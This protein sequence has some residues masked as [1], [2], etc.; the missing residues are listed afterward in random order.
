LLCPLSARAEPSQGGSL[1][2]DPGT[3]TLREPVRLEYP[4]EAGQ[5]HGDVR[6]RLRVSAQGDVLAVLAVEGPAVFAAAAERAAARL[7]FAPALREGRPVEA[8]VSVSF[9]FA[10]PEPLPIEEIVVT[11]EA[12]RHP[13]T[14][15]VAVL[16]KAA[17]DRA[18][19]LGLA[20]A[21]AT[22]PGVWVAPGA[23]DVAKPIVRGQTE[24]R[25]LVLVDGVRHESQKWGADHAPEIDPLLAGEVT[26][27]RGAAGVRYGP[28]A[29]GGVIL[30]DALPLRHEPGV[31]G[32]VLSFG[33]LNGPH[34]GAAA[35][36][37][38]A[39]SSDWSWRV[40][41][42]VQ[43]GGPVMTPTYR[44]GNTASHQR[45]VGA[46]LEHH[47][48]AGWARLS[49]T[50][51]HQTAGIYYG[52]STATPV[53]FQALVEADRPVGAD[54]WTGDWRI[55]RPSQSVSHDRVLAQSRLGL[56]QDASLETSYAF[57]LNH[58]REF[59]HARQGVE[60]PQFN[61]L[62]R[63]HALDLALTLPHAHLGP[64][65]LDSRLGAQGSFQE[66]VYDGL[67]LIPN[68]RSFGGGAYLL[69]ELRT[70]R[71]GLT[72]GARY[73]ALSRRAFFGASDFERHRDRGTLD[74]R[75]C[76]GA[77]SA[78]SCR[79]LYDALT[80]TLGG[81]LRAPDQGWE[82][83]LDLSSATRFPQVD[84]LYL[85][86]T[87]PSTPVF[88]LGDPGLAPETTWGASPTARLSQPWLAAELSAWAQR[89][90]RYIQFA[91]DLNP[92]GQP[93]F[94]VTISGAYPRFAFSPVTAALV[95]ADATLQIGPTSPV[96]VDLIGALVRG[97]AQET[98][99]ALLGLPGD[100]ARVSLVG[101]PPGP[102]ATRL[103]VHA[104]AIGRQSRVNPQ[105]DL[106]PPP[107]GAVLLGAAA[108]LERPWRQQTARATLE[109]TNLLNARWREYTSLIRYYADQPGRDV[110]LVLGT[111]F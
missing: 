39:T 100:R 34:L 41:G 2:A 97:L 22:L 46:A 38:G 75:T 95:G 82:L 99:E 1:A 52:F 67:T 54:R 104:E 26:L 49:W 15:S 18:A 64:A 4:K 68:H 8:E 27:V 69:E 76:E 80:A 11:A 19:G 60:G 35:R 48:R 42:A 58:R 84:E 25:L 103:E 13:S 7:H 92:D 16:D 5:E 32:E 89:T 110:R 96:G 12:D 61:F 111:S 3:P 107:D 105:L 98:G 94:E 87:A 72:A 23:S 55:D 43:G 53:E 93:G 65:R 66:N 6:V 40:H 14:R 90:E 51:F 24:R 71:F 47:G 29:V 50:R 108:S 20:E 91:P 36:L 81:A 74:P 83:A 109:A 30:V 73:D 106:A 88:A 59:D 63:T 44:L 56:W 45:S 86:G 9:H 79:A 62:L 78:P 77:P 17:L 31:G 70:E 102:G 85:L 101:R 57:Q 10:P 37:D 28:D 21:L 33:A